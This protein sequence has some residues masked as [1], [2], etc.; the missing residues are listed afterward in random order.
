MCRWEKNI[1]PVALE[2]F[3]HEAIDSLEFNDAASAHYDGLTTDFL[4]LAHRM[5]GEEGWTFFGMFDGLDHS[6]SGR[7]I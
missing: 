1:D 3:A 6:C 4:S 5:S 2:I 7:G